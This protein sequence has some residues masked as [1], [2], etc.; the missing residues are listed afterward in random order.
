MSSHDA[1]RH[2]SIRGPNIAKGRSALAR[3]WASRGSGNWTQSEEGLDPAEAARRLASTGPNQLAVASR[4]NPLFRFLAQ[5]NNILIYFLLA[6]ATAAGLLGHLI[7]A[8]VILAGVLINATVGFV[9][10]GK[11]EKALDAIRHDR[12]ACNG[13]AR[14]QTTQHRCPRDRHRRH[15]PRRSWTRRPPT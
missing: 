9:Q 4:T 15:H 6:A 14:R 8:A 5:F 2:S 7:D 10:E 1:A 13:A 3:A 12:A 11:A